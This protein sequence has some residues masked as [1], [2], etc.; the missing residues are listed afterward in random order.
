MIST[1]NIIIYRVAE[2]IRTSRINYFSVSKSFEAR[3]ITRVL[4]LKPSLDYLIKLG[5]KLHQSIYFA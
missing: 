1:S 3:S 4:K 2:S 5:P